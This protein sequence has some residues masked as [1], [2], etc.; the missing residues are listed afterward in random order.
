MLL[1]F[2]ITIAPLAFIAQTRDPVTINGVLRAGCKLIWPTTVLAGGAYF[3]ILSGVNTAATF[4]EMASATAGAVISLTALYFAGGVLS[5]TLYHALCVPPSGTDPH[6]TEDKTFLQSA[7]AVHDSLI[8]SLPMALVG[9]VLLAIGGFIV[10][11]IASIPT[12]TVSSLSG[13][14]VATVVSRHH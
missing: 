12:T 5:H 9:G 14:S 11:G 10:G 1:G 4:G 2:G 8:Y 3:K 6:Y 7:S 13:T